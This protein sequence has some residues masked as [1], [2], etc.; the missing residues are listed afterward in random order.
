MSIQ[1]AYENVG[2]GP[3]RLRFDITVTNPFKSKS[4]SERAKVDTGADATEIPVTLKN[5]LDLKPHG[6]RTVMYGDQV[7]RQKPTFV[8]DVFF[9]GFTCQNIEV[10]VQTRS[11]ILLGRDVLNQ[12]RMLCDGINQV[13]NFEQ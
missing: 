6:S 8:V 2:S 13:F 12:F 4:F 5:K 9:D 10:T 7:P 11:D 1:H 3:G